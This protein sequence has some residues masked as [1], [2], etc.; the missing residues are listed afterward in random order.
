MFTFGQ[1]NY[2]KSMKHIKTAVALKPSV[3]QHKD[4]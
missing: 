2:A 4:Y 1:L 3:L